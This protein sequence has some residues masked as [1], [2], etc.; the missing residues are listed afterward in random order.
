LLRLGL[1]EPLAIIGHN[2]NDVLAH[3][4]VTDTRHL[5]AFAVVD[6]DADADIPTRTSAP[7]ARRQPDG[8]RGE[9]FS[10]PHDLLCSLTPAAYRRNIYHLFVLPTWHLAP[11]I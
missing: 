8:I 1:R 11:G 6:A 9:H 7:T 3:S 5:S 2:N 10:E 4:H